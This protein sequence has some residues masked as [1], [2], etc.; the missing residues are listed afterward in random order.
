MMKQ[1][2]SN[3]MKSDHYSRVNKIV[4]IERIEARIK[5]KP[6]KPSSPEIK[7]TQFPL[8]LAWACTVHKVQ[9]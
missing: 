7:R 9:G 8:M 6:N 1:L 4:P 5:I 2:E 3:K